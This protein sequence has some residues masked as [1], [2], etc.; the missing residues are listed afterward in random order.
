MTEPMFSH[1]GESGT[2]TSPYRTGVSAWHLSI[3]AVT[4]AALAVTRDRGADLM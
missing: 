2:E 1:G 4:W 3:T